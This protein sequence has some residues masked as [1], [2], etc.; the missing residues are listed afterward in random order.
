MICDWVAKRR[1][2][3]LF[4]CCGPA[5]R[6]AWDEPRLRCNAARRALVKNGANM[7]SVR[8]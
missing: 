7:I 2:A 6:R 3:T 1:P 4:S 5:K 8:P